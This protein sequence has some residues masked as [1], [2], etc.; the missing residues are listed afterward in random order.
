VVRRRTR[1][2]FTSRDVSE[3][4]GN[5][6]RFKKSREAIMFSRRG[7][8]RCA[9]ATSIAQLLPDGARAL[10]YPTRP[11]H[12]VVTTAPGGTADIV[13]RLMG[14]SLSERMGQTFLIDNRPGAGGNIATEFVHRAPADG[15]TL[16]AVTRGNVISNLLYDKLEYDFPR[17]F[18]AVAGIAN[19][20]LLMLVNSS[21][22]AKTLP[23]FI[24][25]AKS[26]PSKIN[27][28]SAGNGTDPHLSGELFKMM[29]GAPMTHVPYRGGALALTD[30][31]AGS[32]QVMFSNLP[33]A[34]YIKSGKLT[35]LGVTATER[36]SEYPDLAPIADVVPGYE[37]GVWYA[38]VGRRDTPADAIQTL[39][40]AMNQA[41]SEPKARAGLAVLNATP[42]PMNPV[43][44]EKLFTSETAKWG[45]VIKSANIKPE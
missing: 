13:S 21:V 34:D 27:Y 14:Q 22:P 17:D 4:N 12:I 32:V 36:L 9:G 31:L 26:N 42:M 2:L 3:K 20:G 18:G 39:N 41:L 29:T 40:N 38:F 45:N 23:E 7:V 5:W 6:Y 24:A 8:L 33:V 10:D 16:L 11:V 37:V 15:Y 1:R 28:A 19:G 35:A 43:D 25:Y 44:L 30:L